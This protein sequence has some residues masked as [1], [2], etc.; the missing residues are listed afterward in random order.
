[1]A[2]FP[3]ESEQSLGSKKGCD[4][5]ASEKFVSGSAKPEARKCNPHRPNPQSTSSINP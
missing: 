2:G 5:G 4:K 1:M 3:A